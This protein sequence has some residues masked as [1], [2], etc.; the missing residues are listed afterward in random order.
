MVVPKMDIIVY[1]KNVEIENKERLNYTMIDILQETYFL[2]KSNNPELFEEHYRL[3]LLLAE[4]SSKVG[5]PLWEFKNLML[6]AIYTEILIE[7]KEREYR[8]R[9]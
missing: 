2:T 6:S 9:N 5:I 7:K 8:G 3:Q 4:V 1:V